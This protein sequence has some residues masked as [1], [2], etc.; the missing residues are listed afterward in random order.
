M[1]CSLKSRTGGLVV[2]AILFKYSNYN[3][4]IVKETN[5]WRVKVFFFFAWDRCCFSGRNVM[6]VGRTDRMTDRNTE[7]FPHITA[8]CKLPKTL[9]VTTLLLFGRV[10]FLCFI[11]HYI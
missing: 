11:I 9:P 1:E 5:T 8:V 4:T 3:N 10:M 6:R 7:A 2:A